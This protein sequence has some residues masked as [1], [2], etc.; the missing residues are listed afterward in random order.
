M[1]NTIPLQLQDGWP[2]ASPVEANMDMQSM[3]DLTQWIEE[4]YK[5]HN[6]HAVLIEHSG[7][8]IYEL[9]LDGEDGNAGHRKFNVNSL[10]DVR[11]I[12]KS[13]TSLLLGIAFE[14]DYGRAL[15]TP[16]TEYFKNSNIIFGAGVEEV[17]LQHVLTMTAGLEWDEWTLPYSDPQNDARQRYRAEDPDAFTLGRSVKNRPGSHWVYNGGLT[18]LLV[19]VI[20][21]KT[22]KRFRKFATEVLFEPLG[23]NNFEWWGA[24]IGNRKA[25]LT[26]RR[27]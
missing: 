16:I 1:L 7:R 18:D 20:E 12:S 27:V 15:S 17:T 23:I 8:L 4:T 21:Q 9:Y 19:S 5:H 26:A 2:I 11:S 6:T 10:H 13:V 24:D 3:V 22:G 25:G 14:G